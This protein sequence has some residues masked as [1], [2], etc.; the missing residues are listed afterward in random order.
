MYA[1]RSYYEV[2]V[3]HDRIDNSL[4][5]FYVTNEDSLEFKFSIPK[6]QKT[7][8]RIYEATYDLFDNPIFEV[9]E[10]P[11]TIRIT[12]YNVCYTKLLRNFRDP[13]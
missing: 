7:E 13:C 4:F 6:N 2:S 11:S 10:R 3:F 12:S 5:S 1:I 9:H 8:L